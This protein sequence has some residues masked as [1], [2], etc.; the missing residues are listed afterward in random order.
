M[1]E[2]MDRTCGVWNDA[3][4][5]GNKDD[6]KGTDLYICPPHL[7]MFAFY[8]WSD[9]PTREKG[10][11]HGPQIAGLYCQLAEAETVLSKGEWWGQDSRAW[12]EHGA[13]GK[14]LPKQDEGRRRFQTHPATKNAEYSGYLG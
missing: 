5:E 10:E 12:G 11:V 9:G 7:P 2:D 8:G 14:V 13:K 3:R 1:T 6:S 4:K